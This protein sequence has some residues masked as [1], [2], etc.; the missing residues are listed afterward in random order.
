MIIFSLVAQI[1]GIVLGVVSFSLILRSKK[2]YRY[3]SEVYGEL[4]KVVWP[5][6]DSTLKLTVSIVIGVGIVAIFLGLMD[7]AIGK[8]FELLY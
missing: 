4:T 1:T 7:L 8:L 2:A 6:K 3:L 5:D